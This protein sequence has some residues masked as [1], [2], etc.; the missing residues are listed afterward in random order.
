MTNKIKLKNSSWT[1]GRK[2]PKSF[3]K[4]IAKSVPFY[5]EGHKVITNLS[6]FF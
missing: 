3:E 4:H 2:V 5:N 1:F 6:D